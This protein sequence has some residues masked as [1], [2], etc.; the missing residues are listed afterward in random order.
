MRSIVVPFMS[1]A[2]LL[3][4]L[5]SLADSFSDGMRMHLQK[6][7]F[8][9]SQ[10]FHS[11]AQ[12]GN[13]RAQFML[14]TIYEQGLGRPSDL[15]A[16]AYWFEK[17]ANGNN[18]SAQF[19]LGIFYQF[20]KGVPKDASK[21]AQW[22]QRAA[23]NGHGKAQNNLSTFFYAGVGVK[24]DILEAWKWLSLAADHLEG[25]GREMVVKNRLALE[26][27]MSSDQIIDAKKRT[28]MWRASN[29]N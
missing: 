17:A 28:A 24:Q 26:K 16:A 19:N 27:E 11:L 12:S 23:N 8:K 18:P 25:E 15:N 1:V 6:K 3:W 4:S 10:L 21:A 13:V 22:L 9:S 14:G 2:I 5:P 20:G 29:K 7:Y